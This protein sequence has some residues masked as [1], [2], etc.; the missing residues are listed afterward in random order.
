MFL[1][2]KPL[3]GTAQKT[4]QSTHLKFTSGLERHVIQSDANWKF[5]TVGAA[6]GRPLNSDSP[7]ELAV[8]LHT[9]QQNNQAAVLQT[10]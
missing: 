1:S 7:T 3:Q 6:A 2:G 10:V 8:H 4:E 9:L 5:C